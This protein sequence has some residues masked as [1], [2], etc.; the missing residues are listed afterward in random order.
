MCF[1]E[2][3]HAGAGQSAV[4]SSS[5]ASQADDD[6]TARQQ[7]PLPQQTLTANAEATGAPTVKQTIAKAAFEGRLTRELDKINA[8]RKEIAP[9]VYGLD[10]GRF[11][12]PLCQD[13]TFYPSSRYVSAVFTARCTIVPKY[14]SLVWLQ[15]QTCYMRAR[16]VRLFGFF[17][18]TTPI[19]RTDGAVP[20][21]V[22]A[23][24]SLSGIAVLKAAHVR[25]IAPSCERLSLSI[26]NDDTT[27]TI[28]IY[29]DTLSRQLEALRTRLGDR[30]KVFSYQEASGKFEIPTPLYADLLGAAD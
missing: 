27:T 24:E 4:A 2:V 22:H 13:V 28:E 1:G 12:S 25:L 9:L 17:E 10:D 6:A 8:M 16:L 23:T 19:Q 5:S 3:T 20:F 30:L 14:A 11:A 15:F 29:T 18:E 21:Q 7:R 26:D